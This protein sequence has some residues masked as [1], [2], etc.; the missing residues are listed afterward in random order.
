LRPSS[1]A[2][3]GDTIGRAIANS[4][5]AV[6]GFFHVASQS[7]IESRLKKPTLL[8]YFEITRA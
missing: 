2:S 3:Q 4:K 5:E 7:E 1:D 6:E 8:T